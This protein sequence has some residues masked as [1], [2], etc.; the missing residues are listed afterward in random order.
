M[1]KRFLF[2]TLLI[3]I[4][5]STV[6][7]AQIKKVRKQMTLYNYSEAL[8]IL[9]KMAK[10]DHD[11]K[12][13]VFLLMAQC[14]QKQHD[15]RSARGWYAKAL[16]YGAIEPT[17]LYD[18]AKVLQT[19]GDYP[20]AKEYFLKYK[21]LIPGDQRSSILATFCDS[22]LAW[23]DLPP[24]FEVKNATT[25]NSKQSEFG[26]VFYG[27]RLC[28]TSDRLVSDQSD[29]KYGWTGNAYLHLYFA[30]PEYQDDF[31]HDFTEVQ[32][33]PDLFNK[34]YHDGPAS[35]CSDDKE[36][37]FNRTLVQKDKGKKDQDMIRTHLLK[38]FSSTRNGS[39]WL[40]PSPF[41]LNSNTYSVG[42]PA[43]SKDCSLLYFVSDME[44]GF[45]GTDIYV[46]HRE[47]QSW[48]K[49]VN[50]GPVINTFGDE[51]FPFLSESGDLYFASD[52]HPG[53]G[54]LDVF[55]TRQMA[56]SSWFQPGNLGKP[57]NSSFDDF[58]IVITKDNKQGV[59][60]SNRPGGVGDDDLY[61]FERLE[62][63]VPLTK[64][65]YLTGYVKEKTSLQPIPNATVFAFNLE[66]NQVLI[67]KTDSNGYY[68][69]PVIP[70]KS[71]NVKAMQPGYIT[72]CYF[73]VPDTTGGVT[74][75]S[76][77]RDLL[78]D[79]LEE[80]K[81]FVLQNIYYDLDKWNI[82]PDAEP[83]LD[84]LV[85]IMK[86]NPV[87]IELGSY[88]DCRASEAYNLE[89]SQKRAESAVRY[90]VL[91]GINPTRI[92]AKG[93]GESHPVNN[94]VD[95]VPCTEEK[96][97]MNRRTEFKVVSWYNDIHEETFS[98]SRYRN[99]ELIDVRLFPDSFFDHCK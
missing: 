53:F 63:Y 14:Y 37:L 82:R 29:K 73:L 94:C 79:I 34:T 74:E 16:E 62:K 83:A 38:I 32:L 19:C 21:E 71:Y 58:S 70:G 15:V 57:I 86:E 56:D 85:T 64:T 59:F 95:G 81:T 33:A 68:R 67:L 98:P 48:S 72:D 76:A 2:I 27:P 88:T 25:L 23:K 55:I 49:A 66:K 12:Q 10:K 35:F 87:N 84:N 22:A 30:S 54:G 46:C 52:G 41:F 39:R 45:G 99:G 91:Q 3:A 92:T 18:Y 78:L 36:V 24:V 44:G 80:E 93:Y 9:N 89:L 60:S 28:F 77:P 13:E 51:M 90:I 8:S 65:V 7:F 11:D 6:A 5:I 75:L 96:H 69:M 1:N 61:V 31:Y 20:K 50:L 42:H 4:G 97:Q 17:Q 43:L 40:K 26:P 47:G